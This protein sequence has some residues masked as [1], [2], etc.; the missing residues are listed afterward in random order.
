MSF[1]KSRSRH[2]GLNPWLTV[3]NTGSL[4]DTYQL[5]LDLPTGWTGQLLVNGR[6]IDQLSLTPFIFNSADIQVI[7]TPPMGAAQGLYPFTVAIISQTDPADS[8]A[9]PGRY[10]VGPRGVTV[11]VPKVSAM[12]IT[13]VPFGKAA[14]ATRIVSSGIV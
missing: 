12:V 14:Q 13:V 10:T 5:E 1:Q 6:P 7:V 8:T 3:T 11:D 9:I 4:S 2:S